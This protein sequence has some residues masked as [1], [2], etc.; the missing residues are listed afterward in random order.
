MSPGGSDHRDGK[1]APR[2][3]RSALP[4]IWIAESAFGK[5]A[6]RA[7]PPAG[8]IRYCAAFG[9]VNTSTVTAG[10]VYFSTSP[11]ID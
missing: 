9:A 6:G 4:V 2:S 10:P 7:P 5:P 8:A 1:G 11:T 3:L